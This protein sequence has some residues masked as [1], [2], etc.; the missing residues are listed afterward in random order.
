MGSAGK[1]AVMAWKVDAGQWKGVKLGG[2]GAAL[3][4]NSEGTLG[5]D[6]V[7][8]MQAGAIKSV[9]VVD[10]KANAEQEQA[11]VDF[12]RKSASDVIGKVQVVK[13]APISLKN[14]HLA[15]NGVFQAGRI[16]RIETRAYRKTDC[17][18][19]NEGIFYQ[20]LSKVDNFSPAYAKTLT[21]TGDGLDSQWELHN[22]R[23]AFLATFER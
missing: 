15:G 14:D 21:Y 18:C 5:F 7:F 1:E 17:C 2:L 10:E 6:G 16:A 23:S 3:V 11:L 12:V 13:R 20:P 4:L 9:I 22:V 8:P 19:T